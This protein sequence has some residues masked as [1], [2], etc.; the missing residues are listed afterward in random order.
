MYRTKRKAVY[1]VVV[2]MHA[3]FHSYVIICI[4]RLIKIYLNLQFF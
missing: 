1:R 4:D 3:F 2:F